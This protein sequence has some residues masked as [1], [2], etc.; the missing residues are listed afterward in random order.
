MTDLYLVE[1]QCYDDALAG[2]RVLRFANYIGF[3]T[4]PSESPA[5]TTYEPR[6]ISAGNFEQHIYKSSTTSG[7]SE[8]GFGAIV[9]NNADGALDT[10]IDYGF[11]GR[12]LIIWR[13]EAGAAYPAGFTKIF[14]GTIEQPEF[15]LNT[16]TLRIRDRLAEVADKPL[17]AIKYSGTNAL[18]AGVEGVADDLKGSPKPLL[19][20]VA[21]NFSPPLVNT[22]RLIYQIS[23]NQ[24]SSIQNV[25]DNGAAIT[26][27]TSRASL[28][29][30]EATAPTAGQYDYYVGSASDGA[31]IRL[32]SSPAGTVTVNATEGANA[33]NRTVAQ[34][35]SA[36]LQ[37][38]GGIA[39][40]DI[41]S[42]TITALDAANN[43]EVGFWQGTE[44]TTAGEIIDMLC[45]SIGAFWTINANGKFVVG[46]L[47]LPSGTPVAVF[48]S[49]HLLAVSLL[50]SNDAGRGIPVY[51][52]NLAYQRNYTQQSESDVAGSVSLERRNFLK[53][54]MR[55]VNSTDNSVKTK[56]LL[57]KE[58][59]TEGLLISAAAAATEAARLQALYGV[60][61]DLLQI[62][63]QSSDIAVIELNDVV[64]IKIPRLGWSSGKDFRVI[65]RIQNFELDITELVLWG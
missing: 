11:D 8:V 44:E 10:L 12:Q 16:V 53:E 42:A 6:I 39:A 28:A 9:L 47:E 35:I 58:L 17:Q 50:A 41:D 65:G 34:I 59:N 46:R 52:V 5:N 64:C 51:R 61:R 49:Y 19:K 25:Y 3:I 37:S 18:P 24:I 23:S 31:Y 60:R 45:A 38:S 57:A 56:H 30:L 21:F 22:S 40:G 32:G 7:R 20:G 2:T 62:S 26:T 55:L 54:T 1:I 36:V 43:S 29:A 63:L 15:S 48:Q 27:G 4:K 33:S 13:G 14:T